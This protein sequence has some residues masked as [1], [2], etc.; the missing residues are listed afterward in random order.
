M[1]A[2]YASD[3]NYAAL[4]AISAVSLLKHNPGAKIVLLGYNLEPLLVSRSS[5][6]C[7]SAS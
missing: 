5:M 3:K 4:T 2:I 6:N 7:V 1:T